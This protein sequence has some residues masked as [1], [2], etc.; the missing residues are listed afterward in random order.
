[1]RSFKGIICDD[2]SEFESYM[3]SHAVWSLWAMFELYAQERAEPTFLAVAF[4][5]G[6]D[7]GRRRQ[8]V[9]AKG[10]AKF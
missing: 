7:G 2:V 3:P 8:P 6:G 9:I 5:A 4:S 1:M 10:E